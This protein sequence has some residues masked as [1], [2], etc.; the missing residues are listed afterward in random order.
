[1]LGWLS[2]DPRSRPE[3]ARRVRRALHLEGPDQVTRG[4]D[5]VV[6]PA[7]EPHITILLDTGHVA[8]EVSAVGE[9]L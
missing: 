8:G 6:G 1:M 9:R 5:D 4:F 7:D 3:R 2:S